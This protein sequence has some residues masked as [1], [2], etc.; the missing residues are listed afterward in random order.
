M[1]VLI[2]TNVLVRACCRPAGP[3]HKLTNLLS[4]SPRHR[5]VTSPFILTELVRVLYYPR[6]HVHHRLEPEDIR[7]FVEELQ[8]LADVIDSSL[9]MPGISMSNDPDDNPILQAAVV[10]K[11]DVICTLDRHFFHPDVLHVCALRQIEVMDDVAL[12]KALSK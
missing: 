3:A 5:L 4:A 12:L 8:R 1:R 7:V 11:V 10:G 9:S 2:D 6:L